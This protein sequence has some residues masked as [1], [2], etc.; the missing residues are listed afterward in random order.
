MVSLN[1]NHLPKATSPNAVT[2]IGV[3]AS[4]YE[5]GEDTTFSS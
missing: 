5:L 4:T 2:H 1:P 3:G